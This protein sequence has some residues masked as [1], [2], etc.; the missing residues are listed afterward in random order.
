MSPESLIAHYGY[1][2]LL[3]GTALEGETILLVAAFLANRGYLDLT[4]VMAVGALGAFLGDQSFFQL[5]RRRVGGRLRDFLLQRPHW[6]SRVLR[7]QALLQRYQT[8]VILGFR[9]L[10]GLRM[11]TP[12]AIGM[13]DIR[14]RRFVTL[15]ALA[16]AVWSTLVSLLG[17]VFGA[18]VEKILAQAKHYE[19]WIAV[20]VLAA[21]ALLALWHRWRQNR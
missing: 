21:G 12:F 6:H 4:W 18:A 2:V 3:L 7:A 14:A 19:L 8:P 9:F 11:V 5:G 20:G 1:P 10:Y 15:D 13:S 16:A 17:Y